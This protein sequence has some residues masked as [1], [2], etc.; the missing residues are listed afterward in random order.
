MGI[1]ILPWVESME[2]WKIASSWSGGSWLW[3]VVPALDPNTVGVDP[4]DLYDP[5]GVGDLWYTSGEQFMNNTA[6]PVDVFG[7]TGV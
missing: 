7:L 5:G 6:F 4:G 2:D 3:G 1:T